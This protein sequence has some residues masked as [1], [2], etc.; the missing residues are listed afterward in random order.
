M[1]SETSKRWAKLAAA[2]DKK[3]MDYPKLTPDQ[4]KTLLCLGCGGQDFSRGVKF[5]GSKR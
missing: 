3:K 4:A 5:D 2:A 1:P